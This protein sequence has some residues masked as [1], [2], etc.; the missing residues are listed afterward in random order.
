MFCLEIRR[1]AQERD[2][3]IAELWE[4]GTAGIEEPAPGRLRAYF[5]DGADR[6]ALL[7]RFPGARLRLVPAR[8]W[9]ALAR[10]LF[11]PLAV[12]RRFYLAPP[13][14]SDPTPLGRFRIPVNPGL[15]F[16]TGAHETT[17]LCLE[18]LED[19]LAPGMSVLDVGTG[20]GILARAA[21]LLGAAKI[22][23]CDTDPEAVRIAGELAAAQRFVGS[24]DA[25]RPETADLVVANLSPETIVRLAPAL[26]Q[27]R[28]PGGILLAS[29]FERQELA[30][31]RAAW[32]PARQ[33]RQKGNWALVIA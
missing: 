20:S 4:R 17:Q 18:A 2:L 25:V 26:W 9:A 28:R 16:G 6:R 12:G 31:V 8:D 27:A 33:I 10:D 13:W 7:R 11:P 14:R 21:E 32:P 3:L 24:A 5:E 19:F 15:A 23:A 29:G 30:E 22:Y 1:A